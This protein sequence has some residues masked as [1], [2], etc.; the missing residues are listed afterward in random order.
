LVIKEKGSEEQEVVEELSTSRKA[1]STNQN[2]GKE[3]EK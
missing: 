1:V 2:K 3:G